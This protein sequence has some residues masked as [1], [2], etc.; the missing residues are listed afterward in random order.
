MKH[1]TI[2]SIRVRKAIV[3]NMV[4]LAHAA[5]IAALIGLPFAGYFAFVMG[6]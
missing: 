5:I 1:K 4:E 6:K 3:K 2:Q